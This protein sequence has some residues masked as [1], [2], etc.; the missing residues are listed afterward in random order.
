MGPRVNATV[1]APISAATRRIDAR[2]GADA[3]AP[4]YSGQRHSVPRLVHSPSLQRYVRPFRQRVE[5]LATVASLN[6]HVRPEGTIR[7]GESP[8][9]QGV[10]R[11]RHAPSS[12]R[13]CVPAWQLAAPVE[14]V[15]PP[16]SHDLETVMDPSGHGTCIGAH[17]PSAHRYWRPD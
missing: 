17:S 14:Y 3:L 1:T 9:E 13:N 15:M 16:A 5:L 7:I 10:P 12:Q 2:A 11:V 6:M 8:T 4:A